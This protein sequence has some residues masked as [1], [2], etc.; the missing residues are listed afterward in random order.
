[1]F[2]AIKSLFRKKQPRAMA[3]NAS[4]T[5][6]GGDASPQN[7]VPKRIT[8]AQTVC[9]ERNEKG[10]LCNGFLKQIRTGGEPARIHLRGDDVLFKC[11]SCG[12]R[13]IGPPHGHVRDPQ[14]MERFVE[15]ELSALL[16]AAGGSLPAFARNESGAL[17]QVNPP[18]GHDHAGSTAAKPAPATTP[19]PAATPPADETPEQKRARKLAEAA[20]RKASAAPIAG[21]TGPPPEGE[22]PEQKIARLK[23]VV[24]EA[25]RRKEAGESGAVEAA[26]PSTAPPPA[27]QP[28]PATADVSPPE[29]VK[30]AAKASTGPIAGASGPPPEGETPEQKIAR[31]KAVVAEAK[32]RKEA[33]ESGPATSAPAPR[34]QPV[35]PTTPSLDSSP[36]ADAHRAEAETQAA[37]GQASAV[38]M[39]AA[40]A[41]ASPAAEQKKAAPVASGP[42]PGETHEQKI[43]RL[44][45]V[46]AAAKEKA[47]R[48]GR[49]K[50]N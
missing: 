13:Y 25:K 20:T 26:S 30:Q 37:T 10:K 38:P 6:P 41:T 17:V 33:G 49:A 43:A 23:A 34:T 40:A 36:S 4:E 45:A 39:S 48:E 29:A 12:V 44:K 27:P 31:L 14:K 35:S 50:P 19:A 32:R 18:V 3:A 8:N 42:V 28:S 1:M 2:K 21:A 9:N 15:R 11:Q 24:A 22:T 5:H 7:P 47:E 46:V 16:Q